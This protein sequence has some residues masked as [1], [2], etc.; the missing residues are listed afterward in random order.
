MNNNLE[1]SEEF[2]R[3]KVG[4]ENGFSTP[5]NYFEGIE[6]AVFTTLSSEI[7]PNEHKLEVPSNYF[8]T[9][10]DRILAK[11]SIEKKE[12]KV[13]SL[14]ERMLQIIP[15]AAAA[16]VLLFIGLT[17]FSN[18]TVTFD[19]ITITDIDFWYD[20]NNENISSSDLA[21][22]FE[23]SDFEENIL[24]ENSIEEDSLEEYLNAV[25]PSTLLN[26]IK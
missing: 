25:D 21:M 20:N 3:S 14:R 13:I 18:S 19:D 11:V 26:E 1:H 2:I 12:T 23:A 7:I 6:D 4:L 17:Y 10:E 15:T 16:S 22:V 9:L 8:E 24:S 5:E